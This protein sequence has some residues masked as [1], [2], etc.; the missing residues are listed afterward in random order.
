EKGKSV[1]DYR[2]SLLKNVLRKAMN[3]RLRELRQSTDAP[4]L[5]ASVGWSSLL[6][7]I[8]A[9]SA[10]RVAKPGVD[11]IGF[12]GLA[13][14]MERIQRCGVT[15]TEFTRAIAALQ[16]NNETSYIERDKKKSDSY[17]QGYLSHFLEG[18]IALSDE[19]RYQL[20]KELLPSLTLKEV[21]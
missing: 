3:G 4:Y 15:E 5:Q 13:R 21:N 11:V 2:G 1:G 20:T 6:G 10:F 17:V 19:D 14:K 7:G 18:D 12:K 9:L 16:K 8:D